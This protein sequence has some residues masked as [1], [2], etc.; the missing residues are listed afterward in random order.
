[1][2]AAGNGCRNLQTWVP[3]SVK[4]GQKNA[5]FWP[6]WVPRMSMEGAICIGTNLDDGQTPLI[7]V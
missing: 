6:V 3:K 1:M 2:V 7:P 5:P 4:N